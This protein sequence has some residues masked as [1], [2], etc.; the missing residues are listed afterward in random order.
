MSEQTPSEPNTPDTIRLACDAM[1]GGLARWLRAF[2]YDTFYKEGIEDR[3]LVE[4]ALSEDRLLISSDDRLFERRLLTSGQVKSLALP[5]SLPLMKQVEYV[6]RRLRLTAGETRCARCNG[7][8]RRVQREEVGHIVP[9]RSLIWATE[10]YQCAG[11]G[12]A[13]WDGT[14]WRK[15][16]RWRSRLADWAKA[17]P[18]NQ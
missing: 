15:I 13:Y 1:C 2:G 14:H 10:F 18:A 6:A 16:E 17:E 11:C 9:A 7:E 5:R 12:Q 3:E 4:L 8:L